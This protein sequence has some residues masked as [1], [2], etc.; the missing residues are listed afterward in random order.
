LTLRA[1]KHMP[2]FWPFDQLF[3]GDYPCRLA[4]DHSFSTYSTYVLPSWNGL[5]R[6]ELPSA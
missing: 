5:A 1:T 3:S 2:N 6:N 4:M